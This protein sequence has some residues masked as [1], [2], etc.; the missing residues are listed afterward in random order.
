MKNEEKR[1]I[2]KFSG[3][4]LADNSNKLIFDK[5]KLISIKDIISSFLNNGFKVGVVVGAGNIF[6]GRIAEENG[7]SYVDGDYLGMIGTVIN[8]K[9]ISSILNSFNIPNIIYSALNIE[10]V[11]NKYDIKKAKEDY[12]NNKVVLFGGGIGLPGYTTDT[13]AAKRAIEMNAKM[14]L[15]AKN[16]V[17]GIYD[18]DPNKFK[19]AKFLH[20]LTYSEAIKK[21]LKVMDNSALNLLKDTDVVTR[22]FSSNEKDNFLKIAN[23]DDSIGS[24]ISK[25]E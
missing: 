11:T 7:F 13:T 9:A 19:D 24:I 14:I 15:S 16:G 10:N 5:N 23:G 2:L 21:D 20:Y 1:I 3:E 17:D 22:V 8:V 18:K 6:R 12:D 25:G 4:A